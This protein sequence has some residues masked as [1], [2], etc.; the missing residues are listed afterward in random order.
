MPLSR[1]KVQSE[2][3]ASSAVTGIREVTT[4]NRFPLFSGY[5]PPAH[6]GQC[7][8]EYWITSAKYR[9]RVL[10][11]SIRLH[12]GHWLKHSPTCVSVHDLVTYSLTLDST[13][14][15]TGTCA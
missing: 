8:G 14:I 4:Q 2:K 6:G 9:V 3:E 7:T 10:L 11:V 15:G 13:A 5:V 12:F 1:Q